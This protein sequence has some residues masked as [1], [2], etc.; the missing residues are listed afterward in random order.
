MSAV[1]IIV[2]RGLLMVALVVVPAIVLAADQEPEVEARGVV[3][4][5]AVDRGPGQPDW[6]VFAGFNMQFLQ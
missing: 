6:Q 1:A 3:I 4:L 2:A 5:N